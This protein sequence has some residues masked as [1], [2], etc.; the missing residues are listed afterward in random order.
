RVAP[1]AREDDGR[2]CVRIHRSG[3]QRE[4]VDVQQD[5]RNRHRYDKSELARLGHLARRN[6][7]QVDRL[8]DRAVVRAEVLS[9]LQ[10]A[11]VEERDVRVAL[12]NVEGRIKMAVGCRENNFRAVL[13]HL[14]HYPLRFRRLRYVL[15]TEHLQIRESRFNRL[16]AEICRLVV[17]VIVL[18]AD[19]EKT[20]SRTARA[21]RRNAGLGA[22][23]AASSA[24]V[25]RLAAARDEDDERQGA[26]QQTSELAY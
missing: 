26:E 18:R 9:R 1:A 3:A 10:A 12:R 16:A 20:D 15:R 13:D 21:R 4:R 23:I 8:P 22:R 24:A 7:G 14:F 11:L 5:L 17:A 19:E 6:A 25:T 2:R